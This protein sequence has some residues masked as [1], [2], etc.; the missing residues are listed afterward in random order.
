MIAEVAN[1]IEAQALQLMF[2]YDPAPPFD[3]GSP[4]S[5]PPEITGAVRAQL[6][7]VTAGASAHIARN[8]PA[9]N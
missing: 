8:A 5:A 3:A 4:S 9:A 2:Q 6:A 7:E 1:P